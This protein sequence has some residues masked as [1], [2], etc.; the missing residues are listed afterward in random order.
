MRGR[1]V[2]GTLLFGA[3]LGV[4]LPRLLEPTEA[5]AGVTVIGGTSTL[6]EGGGGAALASG[7]TDNSI[8]RADGVSG[9]IQA[10]L[11]TIEDDGD[12]VPPV[13][14]VY[15]T[16]DVSE[17]GKKLELIP[18]DAISSSRIDLIPDGGLRG[19]LRGSTFTGSADS[20]VFTG[21][22][23]TLPANAVC[24]FRAHFI[25]KRV[26]DAGTGQATSGGYMVISRYITMTTTD[27][28]ATIVS[29]ALVVADQT[30]GVNGDAA[31]SHDAVGLAYVPWAAGTTLTGH[32]WQ[33]TI[34][35][36]EC[37]RL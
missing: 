15:D 26:P 33:C 10:S 16:R 17:D 1:V 31:V 22:T 32:W 6:P 4:V 25:A 9:G 20:S 28:T 5:D 36:I 8:V 35:E 7:A 34:D 29:S 30:S 27:T 37:N 21:C 18:S 12:I 13:G 3:L 23:W 2:L 11:P 19:T 14:A 24:R